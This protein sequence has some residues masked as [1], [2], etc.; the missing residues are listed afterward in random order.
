MR[1]VPEIVTK[2][3]FGPEA[4]LTPVTVGGGGAVYENWSAGLVALVPPAVMTVVSTVPMLPGG[5]V[6]VILVELV[7]V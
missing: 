4:G 5:V 7:T 1:F 2:V 6:A 3:P